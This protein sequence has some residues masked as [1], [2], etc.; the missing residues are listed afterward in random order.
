MTM[1][2]AFWCRG[3]LMYIL[4]G[5]WYY[6][7]W[8][9]MWNFTLPLSLSHTYIGQVIQVRVSGIGRTFYKV[10]SEFDVKRFDFVVDLSK[11]Q[12]LYQQWNGW[13]EYLWMKYQHILAL[14]FEKPLRSSIIHGHIATAIIM[15]INLPF[16]GRNSTTWCLLHCQ[17][18]R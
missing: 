1:S 3:E 6:E 8:V 5:E 9:L 15:D 16:V 7:L 12:V 14:L 13:W 2:V 4:I 10:V 11:A 18:L 17:N